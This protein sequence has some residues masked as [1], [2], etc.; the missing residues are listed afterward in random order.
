LWLA[1][2]EVLAVGRHHLLDLRQHVGVPWPRFA[3]SW[4]RSARRT[5]LPI[6]RLAE[7][8]AFPGSSSRSLSPP[9]RVDLVDVL[10]HPF[11]TWDNFG[12]HCNMP[13]RLFWTA[14]ASSR[15]SKA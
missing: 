11:H 12:A 9:P 7:L 14:S 5:C 1:G 13:S 8:F 3:P 4:A 15:S 2:L 10:H 6:A